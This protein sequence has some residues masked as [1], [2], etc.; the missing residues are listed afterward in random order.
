MGANLKPVKFSTPP[1][2]IWALLV[3][4]AAAFF[5]KLTRTE[6]IDKIGKLW[7]PEFLAA[8]YMP[9]VEYI[10][11]HRARAVMAAKFEQEFGDFDLLVTDHF[12]DDVF[13][14]CNGTGHPQIIIPWGV[15]DKG[16]PRSVSV[17]G[18]LYDEARIAGVAN[19]IQKTRDFHLKRPDS[20]AW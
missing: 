13:T 9:A 12:W 18:R 4:E 16:E 6:G 3:A 19:M 10:N 7:P 14:T 5:D 17:I 1:E 8:R 20:S 11:A 15:S 2:G